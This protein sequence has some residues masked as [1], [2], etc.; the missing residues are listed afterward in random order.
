MKYVLAWTN[1]LTGSAKD[2]EASVRRG[3]EL[4]S[5]WQPP[6]SSTFH[7]FV[8]RLDGNGG[9]AV[10]ETDNPAD[11]LD[12]AAKFGTN[13]EFQLYPVVDISDWVQTLGQGVDFRESIS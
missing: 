1:R 13:N 8:G 4:F 5:K 10:V 12:G 11:L 9:F 6:A 7:Q 3:L 2:N